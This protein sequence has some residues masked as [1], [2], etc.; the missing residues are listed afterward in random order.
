[1]TIASIDLS[2]MAGRM[3]AAAFERA[4]P[5]P[6]VFA[7]ASADFSVTA[8]TLEMP[9]PVTPSTAPVPAA[10]PRPEPA[11]VPV[12]VAVAKPTGAGDL[13]KMRAEVEAEIA[14]ERERMAQALQGRSAPRFRF[15][16]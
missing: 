11:K 9:A 7:I 14:R 8:G 5:L 12:H 10:P 6:A 16:T 13:A 15:G 2:A 4:T 3:V 1:M